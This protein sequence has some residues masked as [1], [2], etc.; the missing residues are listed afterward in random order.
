MKGPGPERSAAPVPANTPWPWLCPSLGGSA[1][2][3]V[4]GPP[5]RDPRLDLWCDSVERAPSLEEARHA[6]GPGTLDLVLLSRTDWADGSAA[7]P[8]LRSCAE[9]LRPGGHAVFVLPGRRHSGLS[10][11]A[12]ARKPARAGFRQ[13]RV[14]LSAPSGRY[15]DTL[16]PLDRRAIRAAERLRGGARGGWAGGLRALLRRALIEVG[17]GGRFYPWALVIAER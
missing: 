11:V 16:V 15:A 6:C 14:H 12:L 13:A 1:L 8:A 5:H 7:V 2:E 3:V 17:S 4:A 10:P 9:L